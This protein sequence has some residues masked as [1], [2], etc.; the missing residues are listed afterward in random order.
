MT[1]AECPALLQFKEG[2]DMSTYMS[3]GSY[4]TQSVAAMIKN[5][6]DR[7]AAIKPMFENIGGKLLGFW[8]CFGEY[9]FVALY[10]MPD[11]VTAGA[12]ALSLGASG[13]L[14]KFHTTELMS[15]T[16]AK[17]SM[18]KASAVTYKAPK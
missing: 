6:Q 13:A 15:S 3:Q 2:F 7:A 5:P 4:S 18:K 14:S 8:F 1:L 16:D 11:N 9:D 10:E 17:K 12:M